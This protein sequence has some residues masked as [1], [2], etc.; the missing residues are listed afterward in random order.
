MATILLATELG[1]GFGHLSKLLQVGRL[2]QSDGHRLVVASPRPRHAQAAVGE[3]CDI[4]QSPVV[5]AVRRPSGETT[6]AAS[7]AEIL[8]RIG[9]GDA[10]ALTAAVGA[11][12]TVFDATGAA[13][14]VADHA[15]TAVLAA[16][17]RPV[18]IVGTGFTVPPTGGA[19]FPP[20]P[21]ALEPG[22]A[23]ARVWPIVRTA[24]DRTGTAPLPPTLTAALRG[25]RRFACCSAVLDPYAP[26]RQ[27]EV[28]GPL[29]TPSAPWPPAE[30]PRVFAY[31]AGGPALERLVLGLMESGVD[32]S[33]FVRD[34]PPFL[35]AVLDRSRVRLLPRLPRLDDVLPA[36]SLVLHHGGTI[37]EAALA[38]GRAQLVAP[39]FAEQ[40]LTARALVDHGVAGVIDAAAGVADIASRIRRMAADAELAA[41]A[42]AAAARLPALGADPAAVIAA[43]CRTLL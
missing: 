35:P 10:P 7:F 16:A 13:L 22:G 8:L 24:L 19:T 29:N 25:D 12:R 9:Y 4:V 23:E 43:A 37:S 17:P 3:T 36:A 42:L 38:G 18:V 28:P 14:I 2:L 31:L 30:R 21:P 5:G 27:G 6:P 40:A 20:L 33:V 39:L 34:A 1:G 41:A 26:Y 11:W 15:P 32:A